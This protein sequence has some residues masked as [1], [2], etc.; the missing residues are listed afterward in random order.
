MKKITISYGCPVDLDE[1]TELYCLNRLSVGDARRFE[2][3]LAVCP[4]CF[5]EAAETDLFLKALL[6]ALRELEDQ[7][8][9]KD[10]RDEKAESDAPRDYTTVRVV[11]RE[12]WL[13]THEKIRATQSPLQTKVSMKKVARQLRRG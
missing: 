2:A 10:Q 6:A 11:S 1:R 7:K 5:Y 12:E 3:H 4:P 9:A 13:L 8:D